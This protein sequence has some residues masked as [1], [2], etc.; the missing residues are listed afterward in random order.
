MG[1]TGFW[2]NGTYFQVNR[3]RESLQ[4]SNSWVSQKDVEEL[5]ISCFGRSISEYPNP[6]RHSHH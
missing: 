5:K 4:S 3:R 6:Y 2:H 1:T